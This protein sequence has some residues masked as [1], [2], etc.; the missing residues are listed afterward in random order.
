MPGTDP[1]D[2]SVKTGNWASGGGDTLTFVSDSDG[3][4]VIVGAG[5]SAWFLVSKDDKPAGT[6]STFT[7]CYVDTEALNNNR[8]VK[9]TY[10]LTE[11]G[12]SFG[13]TDAVEEGSAS[14]AFDAGNFPSGT[15]TLQP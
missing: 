15:Y 6:A 14:V 3:H 8:K 1:G 12:Q 11:G 13:L 9:V 4:Y 10:T 7:V 2:A 5:T